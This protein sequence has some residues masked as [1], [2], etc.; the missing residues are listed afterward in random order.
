M[1]GF[2]LHTGASV[3]CAHSGQATPIVANPRVTVSGQPTVLLTHPW[4]VAGC[5][6]PRAS[7]GPC[8]T[9]QWTLGTVRV[10]SNGQ[11]LVIMD[12]RAICSPTGAP[13][14]PLSAQTRVTAA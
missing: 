11:P 10:I 13:L 7:G 1:P 9:A 4:T 6:L 12:G 5:T 3:L 8:V 2:L 14:L